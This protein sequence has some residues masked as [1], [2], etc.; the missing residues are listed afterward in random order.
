MPVPL[1][2]TDYHRMRFITF[3][4]SLY[5]LD[6]QPAQLLVAVVLKKFD[7]PDMFVARASA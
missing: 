5:Q 1:S 4:A 3:E 6:I 2:L 7:R